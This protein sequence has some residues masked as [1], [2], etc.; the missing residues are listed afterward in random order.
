MAEARSPGLPRYRTFQSQL[1]RAA[2]REPPAKFFHSRG[3]SELALGKAPESVQAAS[4]FLTQRRALLLREALAFSLALVFP[5]LRALVCLFSLFCARLFF[6]A[7]SLI[8]IWAW[9][10]GAASIF[11]GK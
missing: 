5:L 8:S 2:P 9:A 4:A 3:L 10:N 7:T 6:R 1:E 11:S